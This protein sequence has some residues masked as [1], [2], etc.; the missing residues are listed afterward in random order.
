MERYFRRITRLLFF[1]QNLAYLFHKNNLCGYNVSIEKTR[2]VSR[3]WRNT[4][5]DDKDFF[6]HATL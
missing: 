3:C 4:F 5:W 6:K 1:T 2:R